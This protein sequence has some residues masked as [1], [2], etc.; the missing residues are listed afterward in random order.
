MNI[1][2]LRRSVSAREIRHIL[3]LS[4]I[5]KSV[6]NANT[7]VSSFAPLSDANADC[8]SFVDPFSVTSVIDMVTAIKKTKACILMVPF[9]LEVDLL[10]LLESYNLLF[11]DNPRKRF[12]QLIKILGIPPK[13]YI[14][15]GKQC[16]I[17]DQAIIGGTG[18]GYV[19]HDM[20]LEPFPQIGYIHIGDFVT[21]QSFTSV[22]RGS[23][24]TTR[25]GNFTNINKFVNIG[26]ND[27]IGKYCIIQPHACF[28]G[29]VTVGDNTWIGPGAVIKDHINIGSN[30]VIG[31]GSVVVND[32]PNGKTVKGNPAR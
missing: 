22:N 23:L 26:H 14:S 19:I 29:S 30:C 28:C 32:V 9:G 11:V 18:F 1:F 16:N 3:N 24:G 10:S 4:A 21:I 8:I 7:K 13:D 31:A 27:Q 6:G 2:K 15:I 25:I 5:C 17:S 12:I 20:A